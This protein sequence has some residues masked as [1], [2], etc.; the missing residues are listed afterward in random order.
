MKTRMA[1]DA[2][3]RADNAFPAEAHARQAILH[4][5]LRRLP[6]ES[7]RFL[8]SVAGKANSL[9]DQPVAGNL[10]LLRCR[11]AARFARPECLGDANHND[12]SA[13]DRSTQSAFGLRFA[14]T[15]F[16]ATV[17]VTFWLAKLC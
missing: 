9:C 8:L 5:L 1:R 13:L 3:C 16:A 6:A 4:A 7:L 10:S 17:L 14:L 15:E 11:S 12:R 2:V